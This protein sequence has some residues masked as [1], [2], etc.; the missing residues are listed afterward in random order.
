MIKKIWNFFTSIKLSIYLGLLLIV[1]TCIGAFYLQNN[2]EFFAEID[3][4]VFR[5][6]LID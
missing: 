4:T 2:S 5:L 1:I 6:W 3:I